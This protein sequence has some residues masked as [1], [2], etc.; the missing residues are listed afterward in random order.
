MEQLKE[1]N[2]MDIIDLIKKAEKGYIEE[3]ELVEQ[4]GLLHDPTLNVE[5]LELLKS[6]NVK[7]IYVTY[8]EEDE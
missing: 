2:L 4:I 6:L 7:I 3:L 8:D 1:R 5:V